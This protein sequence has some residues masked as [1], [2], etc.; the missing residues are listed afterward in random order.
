MKSGR[1]LENVKRKL[2]GKPVYSDAEY[3]EYLLDLEFV[4]ERMGGVGGGG[5]NGKKGKKN[6]R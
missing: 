1:H 5:G 3:K 4:N 2:A 6:R